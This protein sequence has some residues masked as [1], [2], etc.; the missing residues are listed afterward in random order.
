LNTQSKDKLKNGDWAGYGQLQQQM[1]E[2]VRQL[3]KLS[4]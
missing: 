2:V 3:E 4:K 1:D